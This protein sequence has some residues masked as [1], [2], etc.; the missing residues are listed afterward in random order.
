MKVVITN[1][2]KADLVNIAEFISQ[3]NPQRAISFVDELLDRCLSLSD[4]PRAYPLV[5]RYAHYGVRRCIHYDYLIFYRISEDFLEI[6]H[7]LHGARDYEALLFSE[8]S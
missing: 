5:S 3:N 4:M 6:I 7:I 2:A 8:N 1:A